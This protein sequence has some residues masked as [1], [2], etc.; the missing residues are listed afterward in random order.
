MG[1][2]LFIQPE[3]YTPAFEKYAANLVPCLTRDNYRKYTDLVKKS[4][5][6]ELAYEPGIEKEFAGLRAIKPDL[7]IAVGLPLDAKAAERALELAGTAW[8]HSIFTAPMTDAKSGA[9]N[10]RYLKDMIREVHLKLVD[11]KIRH[12]VNLI[13]SGGIA[14]A[15]HMAKSLICGATPWPSIFRC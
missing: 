13:F 6:V 15:E 4:R 9:E 10:P 11:N 12:K 1:T 14:M 7:F 3:S 8:I 5:M 2:L